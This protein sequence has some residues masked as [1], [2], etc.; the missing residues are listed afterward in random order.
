MDNMF[1]NAKVTSIDL[2]KFDVSNV[3]NFSNASIFAGSSLKTINLNNWNFS[4]ATS[5]YYLFAGAIYAESISLKNVNT[6]TITD[7]GYMFSGL[8]KL[9]SI[10]LS[11]FDTSSL[12]NANWMFGGCTS[13]KSI[14]MDNWDFA[15]LTNLSSFFNGVSSVQEISLKNVNTSNVTS[16]ASMFYGCSSLKQLDLRSFNTSNVTSMDM[17]FVNASSLTTILVSDDFVVDQVTSSS[18]M[19]GNTSSIIGGMGTTY[20]SSH[21]DKAYAHYDGGVS[22][23]GYFQKG[24][25][26]Y[27]TINLNPTGGNVTPISVDVVRTLAIGNLPTPTRTNYT[28]DGWYTAKTGGDLVDSSYVPTKSQTIY[29][30]WTATP[31]HTVTFNGNGGTVSEASRVVVDGEKVGTLPTAS[32]Y[33]YAFDGW[34]L[35]TQSGVKIDHSYVPTTDITVKAKWI[36]IEA[37]FD[38]GIN[39]NEKFKTLAGTELATGY[40]DLYQSSNTNVTAIQ[41]STTEPTAENKTEEHVVSAPNSNVPIYAWFDNGT[42]YWWTSANV[43][44]ANQDAS[45]MFAKFENMTEFSGESINTSQTTLILKMLLI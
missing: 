43:A 17:M 1:T 2:S 4:S 22:N 41:K 11:Y 15:S 38:T 32:R 5:L 14:N 25:A 12:T 30:H 45:Y 21:V 6:S 39:V 16:M 31:T 9:K 13:L 42:I 26:L 35:D 10:D 36:E 8:S 27:Y 18:G 24:N 7:T 40:S 19:F 44:F 33:G 28:F 29:A 34:Y 23:P 37:M 20:D 3:T